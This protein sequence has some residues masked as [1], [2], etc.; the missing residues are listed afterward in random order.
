MLSKIQNINFKKVSQIIVVFVFLV[1]GFFISNTIKV[2]ATT[3]PIITIAPYVTTPTN[4]DITVTASV[5]NGTLVTTSHTFTQNGTFDFVAQDS[6]NY[7]TTKQVVITNID[8]EGFVLGANAFHFSKLLKHGSKDNEVMELQKFLN[9]AGYNIGTP[10][11]YF[12]PMT[13]AA[14]IK[15]QVANGLKGDGIIGALGRAILNK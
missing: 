6:N 4:K 3:G 11:G 15:F 14:V 2:F 12:G 5:Q 13:K 1:G 7:V 10:N 8:K 9:N